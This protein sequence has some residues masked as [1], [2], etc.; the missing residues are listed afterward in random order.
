MAPN[1]VWAIDVGHNEL[2]AVKA[3]RV[4]DRVQIL[5]FDLVEYRQNLAAPG[6]DR[7]VQIQQAVHTFLARND[8]R[9]AALAVVMP[10]PSAL[11]RFI[12]LPPVD[13]SAIADIV[14][15]EARQQIPFPLEEVCWD[16]AA[17]DR[18]FIPGEQV[19][20]GLFAL[21][22]E[23]AYAFTN[24][25]RVAG[26]E[27]DLLQIPPVGLF[28]FVN[29]DR[30]PGREA[31]MVM[32]MGVEN[33]HIL[34]LSEDTVWTRSLP[35]GGHTFTQAI[36][37]ALDVSYEEAEGEK[38]NARKSSRAREIAEAINQPM[39]RL[40]EELQR[41]LGYFRSL[42]PD[43]RVGSIL[44]LGSGFRLPGLARYVTEAT[45]IDIHGLS[46]LEN[47]DLSAARNVNFFK[48]YSSSFP[49]AL[50]TAAQALGIMGTLDSTMLPPEIIRRKLVAQKKPWLV[51]AAAAVLAVVGVLCLAEMTRKRGLEGADTK[52]VEPAKARVDEVKAL[53]NAFNGVSVKAEVDG[54]NTIGAV[55]ADRDIWFALIDELIKPI[56][57]EPDNE[58]LWLIG[59]RATHVTVEEAARGLV[60]MPAELARLT[61]EAGGGSLGGV[62]SAKMNFYRRL[63]EMRTGQSTG[64]RFRRPGFLSGE[65]PERVQVVVL[66][67][68][69]K[70]DDRGLFVQREFVDK[71]D[72]SPLFS[73]SQLVHASPVYRWVDSAGRV[74][75]TEMVERMGLG[76]RMV[77]GVSERPEVPGLT[78]VEYTQFVAKTFVDPQDK[79]KQAVNDQQDRMRMLLE[80]YR[81]LF[82]R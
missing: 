17:I 7:D 63:E 11:V 54:L 30:H 34:C 58:S 82:G 13:R 65:M 39:S 24:C 31:V 22:K 53:R 47:F 35:I 59:F 61:P 20:V 44:A 21:R 62:D 55:F 15:Y 66:W 80:E 26:L 49:V 10:A 51:A 3:Q 9:G 16:H 79:L 75:P 68:E 28:N 29:F 18:G 45:G 74:V 52:L 56:P 43:T 14:E 1:I 5:S 4:G 64:R 12:Q 19:E 78:E 6:V 72:T 40:I 38:L 27:P 32:D 41:S 42:H 81:S 50:G 46:S 23:L 33:T 70:H 36:Q 67:G 37:Q 2:K 71:L 57:Q 60:E 25:L 69:A 77:P 48:R 76:R 73:Y 8:V